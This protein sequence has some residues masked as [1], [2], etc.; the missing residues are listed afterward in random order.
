MAKKCSRKPLIFILPLFGI[1]LAL[2]LSVGI[3]THFQ[4]MTDPV[5]LWSA[6]NSRARTEKEFY[7]KNFNPFYRVQQLIIFPTND[8]TITHFDPTNSSKFTTFGPVFDKE[9]L[10]QVLD[11]Q[12]M[13]TNLTAEIDGHKIVLEDLCFS[14]MNN[15]LCVIQTPLGWF[16]SE[17][18]LIEKVVNKRNYLDHISICLR[19]PMDFSDEMKLSCAGK[20]GGPVFPNVALADFEGDLYSSAKSIVITILLNNHVSNNERAL[21]WEQQFLN[22]MHSYKNAYMKIVYYSEVNIYVN[23]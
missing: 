7:D 18:S 10:L 6:P 21:A 1:V 11:L 12:T 16:Q 19:S 14:P 17:R 2:G 13:V 23:K 15:K 4:A 20:Y 9:F 8:S 5:S 3:L 22:F